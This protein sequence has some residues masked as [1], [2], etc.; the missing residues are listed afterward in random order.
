M[1]AVEWMTLAMTKEAV[2]NVARFLAAR[3]APQIAKVVAGAGTAAADGPLPIGDILAVGFL[4]WTAYDV[5]TLPGKVHAEVNENFHNA[6]AGCMRELDGRIVLAI[7]QLREQG[8]PVRRALAERMAA[9]LKI[10][11]PGA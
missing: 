4:A 2:A 7:G 5:I 3:L 10:S 8:V 1:V 9:N 11:G 6:A